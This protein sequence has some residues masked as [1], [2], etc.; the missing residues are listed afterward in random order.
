[1]SFTDVLLWHS[2]PCSLTR[3]PTS[4]SGTELPVRLGQALYHG[5]VSLYPG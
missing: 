5:C 2:N 3:V 1:M 4:A